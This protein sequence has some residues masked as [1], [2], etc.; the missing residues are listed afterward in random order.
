MMSK[1]FSSMALELH[2][3]CCY[4]LQLHLF[5]QILQFVPNCCLFLLHLHAPQH[6]HASIAPLATPFPLVCSIY[7]LDSCAGS[8]LY[9][10]H[11]LHTVLSIFQS[12]SM[13]LVLVWVNK[14][15]TTKTTI[16]LI[17][18]L[19]ITFW[20]RNISTVPH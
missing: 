20:Y 2:W 9:F 15:V 19:N 10:V 12:A 1:V 6:L 7:T 5:S 13:A 3:S 18:Q 14:N 4:L 17:C 16:L 8:M 11:V